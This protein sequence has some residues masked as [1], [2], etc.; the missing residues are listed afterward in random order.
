MNSV[1]KGLSL[2]CTSCTHREG[3]KDIHSWEQLEQGVEDTAA[4]GTAALPRRGNP[5]A[6]SNAAL[7]HLHPT[8]V[9]FSPAPS[10]W[11]VCFC[12]APCSG[13]VWHLGPEDRRVENAGTALCCTLRSTAGWIVALSM[14]YDRLLIVG[15]VLERYSS[16]TR[17]L[18]NMTVCS[19]HCHVKV[20]GM[21]V[22]HQIQPQLLAH[23]LFFVLPFSS[24]CKEKKWVYRSDG[25]SSHLH[26]VLWDL[27]PT[28]FSFLEVLW[29]NTFEACPGATTANSDSKQ[30]YF[31]RGKTQNL[32]LCNI[33]SSSKNRMR[34]RMQKPEF[35]GLGLTWIS[36]QT[37][38]AHQSVM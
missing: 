18:W 12:S 14:K 3:D 33:P 36:W 10:A 34:V 22:K 15:S 19:T 7:C 32:P 4:R 2:R 38:R 28:S 13:R 8:H 17:F 1:C 30:I 20:V 26:A 23:V 6:L 11:Q 29:Y 16:K 35:R 25:T 21:P 9:C 5:K 27:S 24:S 31:P 37:R